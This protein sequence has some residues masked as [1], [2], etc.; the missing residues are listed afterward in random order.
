[1][2][3][4]AFAGSN[5]G[6][7]D[8]ASTLLHCDDEHTFAQPL[9]ASRTFAQPLDVA[10]RGGAEPWAGERRQLRAEVRRLTEDLHQEKIRRGRDLGALETKLAAATAENSQLNR[11]LQ[12]SHAAA[13]GAVR[14]V[15][16]ER[17]LKH[18]SMHAL[19]SEAGRMH[20]ANSGRLAEE[21]QLAEQRAENA[22]RRQL[23]L[24]QLLA[25]T[26]EEAALMLQQLTG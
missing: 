12:Q 26:Q 14:L 15:E 4:R 19:W 21:R 13:A 9:D 22:L 7:F 5:L 18:E 6:A 1:M 23:E 10:S 16:D 2:R 3:Y 17:D 24:E 25:A 8:D 20:D 11:A